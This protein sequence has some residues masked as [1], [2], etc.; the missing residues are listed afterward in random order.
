MGFG[1]GMVGIMKA[2]GIRV[3]NAESFE[4]KDS[5]V[6]WWVV[7]P[8]LPTDCMVAPSTLRVSDS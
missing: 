2:L 1:E 6:S 8:H 4:S 7:L 5:T 3:G